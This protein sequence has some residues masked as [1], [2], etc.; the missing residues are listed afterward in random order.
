VTQNVRT[1][2]G[3]LC[4]SIRT[5]SPYFAQRKWV[6]RYALLSGA[7]SANPAGRFK[8]HV[9][10]INCYFSNTPADGGFLPKSAARIMNALV[11]FL[12]WVP[13]AANLVVFARI[14]LWPFFIPQPSRDPIYLA[15]FAIIVCASGI[16]FFKGRKNEPRSAGLRLLLVSVFV[17]PLGLLLV[18]HAA[19]CAVSAPLVWLHSIL[20]SAVPESKLVWLMF[21]SMS[22]YYV[23]PTIGVPYVI[24]AAGFLGFAFRYG[25]FSHYRKTMVVFTGIVLLFAGYILWWYVTGQKWTGF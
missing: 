14:L 5:V 18:W 25:T 13:A 11:R 4:S 1:P 10:P 23:L 3:T 16:A 24:V 17:M 21:P 19:F 6:A 22:A 8:T 7:S 9:P 15:W 20:R 12:G 2:V